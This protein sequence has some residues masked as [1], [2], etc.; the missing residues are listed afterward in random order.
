MSVLVAVDLDQTV[1]FSER[2]AGACGPTVVVEHLDDVPLS[3]MTVGARKAY[4]A[5]AARHRVVPVTTR[6]VAQ[7]ARIALPAASP[8][9]VCANGGVLLVD[10]CRDEAWDGWVRT[11]LAGVAPLADVDARVRAGATGG[12]VRTVRTAEDLFVYLV[13]QRRDDVPPDWLAALAADLAPRGWTVSVQGRKVYAVPAGLTK[14]AAVERLAGLLGADVLLAAGDSLL[15]RPLLELAVASGGAAVRPA[16]GELHELGWAP[17]GVHVTEL[18]GARAGE[19]L[20]GWL[21]AQADARA[22]PARR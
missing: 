18:S 12:W 6:T 15:D 3:S 16:H 22:V 4:A 1:V 17:P 7:Y 21:V 20:L 2:S 10:G 8:H 19:E 14:A 11:L 13:A 5:L 9:A